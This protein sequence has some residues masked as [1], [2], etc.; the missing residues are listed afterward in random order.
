MTIANRL[1]SKAFE[2][3]V[4]SPRSAE[5]TFSLDNR[6]RFQTFLESAFG[7]LQIA[8]LARSGRPEN[9]GIISK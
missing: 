5:I 1:R 6:L 4:G 9:L 3:A 7:R 8:L 2:T